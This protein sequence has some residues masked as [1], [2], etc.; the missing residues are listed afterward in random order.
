MQALTFPIIKIHPGCASMHPVLCVVTKP[1]S[2]Q[3]QHCHNHGSVKTAT[4]NQQ[5]VTIG[6]PPKYGVLYFI[7]FIFIEL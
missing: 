1:G 6:I 4:E 3:N 7:V 5:Q 2:K